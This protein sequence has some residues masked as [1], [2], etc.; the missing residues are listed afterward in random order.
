MPIKYSAFVDYSK[1][2]PVKIEALK[3]FGPTLDF[4]ERLG[5]SIVPETLGEAAVAF[6][7]GGDFLL[8]AN[9]EG[10]GTK[11]RIADKM[12]SEVFV[13]KKR[14][15]EGMNVKGLFRGLGQDTVAMS[16]NDLTSIGADP[17]AYFDII[18]CGNS[19][20][21]KDEERLRELLQG[22]RDAADFCQ[23]AIPQGETPE[24]R[25]VVNPDTLDLAGSSLGL[26]R[27]KGR[28]I[29]GRNIQEGDVIYGLDSSG[30]HSNGLTKARKIAERL[31]DGFFTKL[32]NG[33]TL[34]EE[35]LVPTYLYSPQIRRIFEASIDVHYLQPITGHG[36]EKIARYRGKEFTYVITSVPKP[37]LI[38][39]EL[40]RL[41]KKLNA[42][43]SDPDKKFDVSDRENHFTWNMGVGYVLI[44]PEGQ[45]DAIR[46]ATHYDLGVYEIGHVESG[47]RQVV[48]PFEEGG[49]P[50][51][52]TP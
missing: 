13:E 50:V 16:V 15:A 32:A 4:P 39:Q 26:I 45:H 52:Y 7:L 27:P 5:I 41:A 31:P 35:L 37:P 12:Y 22:Y 18:S 48:M 11:N 51:V 34:G 42:L 47:P 20:W 10:L 1:L 23:L 21:F 2:D 6:D 38:F 30:I 17:F 14:V 49:K 40:I 36:W 33:R 8:A 43:E 25:D 9:V 3:L 19:E 24:L 29:L 28:L 44:A 46:R